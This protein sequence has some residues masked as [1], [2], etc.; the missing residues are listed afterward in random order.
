MKN[1]EMQIAETFKRCVFPIFKGLIFESGQNHKR[2]IRDTPVC[3][4]SKSDR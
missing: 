4:Q 2:R 3:P 1:R